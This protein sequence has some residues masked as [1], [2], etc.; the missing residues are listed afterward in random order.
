MKYLSEK[1]RR[2]ILLRLREEGVII[3]DP[4]TTYV[5]D[6]VI[7]KNGTKILPNTVLSGNTVIGNDCTLGP[8]TVIIDS[9]IGANNEI[10]C[11][12]LLEATVENETK[13][14]PFS[15]LRPKAHIKSKAKIG[16]FVEVKNATIGEG[17]KASHLTYIG[18][19]DVGKGCN[20]GCGS[21]VV[22]YDGA[23]KH[24][25]KIGDHAFIGC[26][27]NLVSPVTV[28]PYGYTAAGSTITKDVPGGALAIARANQENKIGWVERK[29]YFKK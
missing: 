5:E 27:T 3:Y 17:T 6:T 20:F 10:L 11:S 25:S 22:N 15:Y 23:K 13:I 19:A 24:R 29:G 21:V 1:N 28:G 8:N 2:E 18:D 9:V 14:G 26:N 4:S 16:N 7:I 12:Y